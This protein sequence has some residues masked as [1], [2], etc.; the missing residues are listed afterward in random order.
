MKNFDDA[1]PSHP[2]KEKQIRFLVNSA[3]RIHTS[4][5]LKTPESGSLMGQGVALLKYAPEQISMETSSDS[6]NS[7]NIESKL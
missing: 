1:L 6:P 3:K 7:Q 2:I 5:K 4:D